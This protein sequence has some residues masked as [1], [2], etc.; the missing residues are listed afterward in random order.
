MTLRDR[1]REATRAL[2]LST[3]AALVAERGAD[4][5]TTRAVAIAAG[6]GVGTVF[7]HFPDKTALF[8]ALLHDHIAGA[9]D[10]GFATLPDAPV[11]EQLLHLSGALYE[12]YDRAPALSRAL[13][14]E[15][16]FLA[17]RDRPLAKQLARFEAW[18]VP[19]L[20]PDAAEAQLLFLAFF[21][22][23]FAVL[24]GSLRGELPVPARLPLLR[25]LLLRALPPA[26]FGGV[27]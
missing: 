9:L 22:Q 19:R 14:Q 26:C 18:A 7:A 3:T 1:Q 11:G 20:G 25:W 27:P 2:L 10:A 15:T 13:I 8:E 16:L 5:V 12:A 24:L 17:D 4:A 23:Y 21:A 6:V